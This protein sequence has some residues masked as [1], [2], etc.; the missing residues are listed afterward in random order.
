MANGAG[1][2]AAH[3]HLPAAEHGGN[4]EGYYCEPD[5]REDQGA[6][7]RSM[8]LMLRTGDPPSRVRLELVRRQHLYLRQH[9][10]VAGAAILV[11]RHQR[12][13]GLGEGGMHLE[14]RSPEPP[15]Y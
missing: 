3:P 14:T 13:A 6:V 12:L 10:A 9:R 2:R 5:M 4:R 11:A 8:S 15:W 1:N 7:Q